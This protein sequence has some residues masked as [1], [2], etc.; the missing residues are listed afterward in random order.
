VA[1]FVIPFG[2]VINLNGSALSYLALGPFV[3]N[4]VFGYEVSWSMMLLAWPILVVF[5]IAAPGLPAGMGTP[6]WAGT[7]FATMVGLEG[8]AQAE[9]I[10]TYI[11]LCGGVTDMFITTVNCTTDGFVSIF[12]DHHSERFFSTGKQ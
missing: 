1:D 9:F 11:A 12:F 2:A 7:L 4:Y 5:T 6:L 8:T 10:A 3:I